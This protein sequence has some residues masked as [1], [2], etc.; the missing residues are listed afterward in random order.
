MLLLLQSCQSTHGHSNAMHCTKHLAR[1]RERERTPATPIPMI[2]LLTLSIDMFDW[3]RLDKVKESIIVKQRV[4][5]GLPMSQLQDTSGHAAIINLPGA[6]PHT[7]QPE[8]N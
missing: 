8:R 6:M 1:E 4:G 2:H 5:C 7:H 3:Y